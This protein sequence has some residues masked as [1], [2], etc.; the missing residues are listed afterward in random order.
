MC[1]TGAHG[2]VQLDMHAIEKLQLRVNAFTVRRSIIQ[3]LPA[4]RSRRRLAASVRVCAC[5]RACACVCVRV[6][7]RVCL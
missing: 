2:R 3:V 1:A 6:R 4:V 5:A 7:M